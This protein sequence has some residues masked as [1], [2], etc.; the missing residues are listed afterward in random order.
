MKYFFLITALLF[1]VPVLAQKMSYDDWKKKAES[2]I[3]LQPE[4]GGVKKTK[5]QVDLDNEFIQTVI[6]QDTTRVKGSE[7][8]VRLGFNYLY[9][10]DLETAMKR[11]N[12]A[13]LLNPKNENA[14]WGYAAVYFGFND[15]AEAKKQLDKGLLINPN[16]A[17]ILTDEA[18]LEM[19]VY[20]ETGN[21]AQLNKALALF[22]QSYKIDPRNQNTLFKLSTAYYYTKDCMNALKYYNE[23]IK[24]GGQQISPDYGDAL[25]KMCNK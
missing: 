13:W 20:M 7:H 5:E 8:L 15:R 2:E 19:S 11:F 22:T 12:Q 4:Y 3:N 10:G 6:K 1:S 25:K 18:T 9:R 16:S 17:N 14:Y 21:I 23:C 24:L